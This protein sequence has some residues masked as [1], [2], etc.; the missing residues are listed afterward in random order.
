[1]LTQDA[2]RHAMLSLAQ[3]DDVSRAVNTYPAFHHLAERFV[4]GESL[5]DAVR[6]ARELNARGLKVSLDHLGENVGERI[7]AIRATSDYLDVLDRIVAERL[8]ANISIK[9]TQIGLG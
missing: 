3:R 8:D 4:A 6:V 9:L 2:I 1:M 5:D 7:E